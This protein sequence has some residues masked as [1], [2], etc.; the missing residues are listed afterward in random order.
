M[1]LSR[2]LDALIAEKVMGYECVCKEEPA[3]CPIHA[4]DDRDTL[5]AYSADIAAAW[6]VDKP[7]WLW[8]FQEAQKVLTVTLY[9]SFGIL[10][11]ATRAYPVLPKSVILVQQEWLE[12][13]VSTYALARCLAALKAVGAEVEDA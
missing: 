3:D 11:E 9:T 1:K 4:Y 13:K 8:E 6:T 2:E 10:I 7:G 12:D 5:R